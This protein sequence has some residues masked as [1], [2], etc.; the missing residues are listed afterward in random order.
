MRLG[1]QE[2]SK[3]QKQRK[4]QALRAVVG[5]ESCNWNCAQYEGVSTR[6]GARPENHLSP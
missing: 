5:T 6:E 2:S 3:P 4:Q 1:L